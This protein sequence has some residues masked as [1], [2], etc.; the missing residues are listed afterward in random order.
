MDDTIRKSVIEV[1]WFIS[2]SWISCIVQTNDFFLPLDWFGF[3]HSHRSKS[4]CHSLLYYWW[5]WRCRRAGVHDWISLN[6]YR[7]IYRY[8]DVKTGEEL[9]QKRCFE[10]YEYYQHRMIIPCLSFAL[11]LGRLLSEIS[12]YIATASLPITACCWICLPD[13]IFFANIEIGCVLRSACHIRL[14]NEAACGYLTATLPKL[15]KVE[16]IYNLERL[17]DFFL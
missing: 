13:Q 11:F 4:A 2:R 17:Q 9:L 1:W 8:L 16:T 12:H 14:D 6:K 3:V 5:E 7:S 15:D 10:N